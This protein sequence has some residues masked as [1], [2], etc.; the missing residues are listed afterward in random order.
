MYTNP[1]QFGQEENSKKITNYLAPRMSFKPI[2]EENL[3]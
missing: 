3:H 2:V 1:K